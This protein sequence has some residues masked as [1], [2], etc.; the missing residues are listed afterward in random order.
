[1]PIYYKSDR[2]AKTELGL[3]IIAI[4]NNIKPDEVLWKCRGKCY[5]KDLRD[6]PLTKHIRLM[7]PS[8]TIRYQCIECGS[9]V[10]FVDEYES[11]F[12]QV[13]ECDRE[14]FINQYNIDKTETKKKIR[15]TRAE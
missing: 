7:Y 8:G 5:K 6:P 1:M 9:A 4:E 14:S 12:D 3:W 10:L 2:R 11:G 13:D 15:A